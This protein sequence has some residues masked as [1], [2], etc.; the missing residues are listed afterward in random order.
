MGTQQWM[1]WER[2]KGREKGRGSSVE[3]VNSLQKLRKHCSKSLTELYVVL[4]I[5]IIHKLSKLGIQGWVL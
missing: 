3:D 2:E 1:V 4:Y 5:E